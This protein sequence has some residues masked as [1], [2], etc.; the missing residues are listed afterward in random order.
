MQIDLTEIVLA[1]LGLCSALVTGVLLPWLKTRLAAAQLEKLE[2]WAKI[3]VAAAEQL[4]GAGNGEAKLDY[5]VQY[6]KSRGIELDMAV[7]EAKVGE[8]FGH[9][10]GAAA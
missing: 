7:I 6:L 5:A 2:A 1:V 4:Y 10:K 3:A 9:G 8:L